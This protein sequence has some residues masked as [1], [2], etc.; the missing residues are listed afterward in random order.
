MSR[1]QE[2]YDWCGDPSFMSIFGNVFFEKNRHKNDL[3]RLGPRTVG[4]AS[5]EALI[6]RSQLSG[7]SEVHIPVSR[8]IMFQEAQL[9]CS[10]YQQILHSTNTCFLKT[11]LQFSFTL[12]LHTYD[13]YRQKLDSTNRRF[14]KSS[15]EL[16]GTI[17]SER[18]LEKSYELTCRHK[19]ILRSQIL[20]LITNVS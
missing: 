2:G 15:S 14:L 20:L 18:F 1:D 13:R 5:T 7:A 9:L 10:K 8:Q 3:T 19:L 6:Q 11:L 4:C 12:V 16:V 17:R